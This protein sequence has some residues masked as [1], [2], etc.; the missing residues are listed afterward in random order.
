MKL[1][2]TAWKTYTFSFKGIMKGVL[3]RNDNT[4]EIVVNPIT[5]IGKNI[6]P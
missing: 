6:I 1:E 4:E 5:V 3:L 2:F